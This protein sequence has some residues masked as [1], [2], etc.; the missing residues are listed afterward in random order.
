VNPGSPMPSFQGLGDVRLK[1]I[2]TFLE[3]SKGGK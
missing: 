1:E 2:A 3:S